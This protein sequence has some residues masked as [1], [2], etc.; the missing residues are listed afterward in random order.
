MQQTYQDGSVSLQVR[1]FE[2]YGKLR[3][4]QFIAIPHA[5]IKRSKHHFHTLPCGIDV[6]LGLNGYVWLSRPPA[7]GTGEAQ[8]LDKA[9]REKV[10][11]VRNCIAALAS[12]FIAVYA[13]SIMDTYNASTHLPVKDML[14]EDVIDLITE[15]AA[16][17]KGKGE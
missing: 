17:R 1:N 2:K 15:R 10:A 3:Y 4:G 6:I 12:K 11:R 5:L 8:V 7:E 9:E 16:Q 13:T 14:R